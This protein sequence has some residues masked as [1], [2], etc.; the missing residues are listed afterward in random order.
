MAHG[1]GFGV[2]VVRANER[3]GQ[4]RK[5]GIKARHGGSSNE[6]GFDWGTEDALIE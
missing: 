2:D 6:C 1:S 4:R 3:W 5:H